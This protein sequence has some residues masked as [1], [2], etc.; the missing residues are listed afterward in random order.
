VS[1]IILKQHK[2]KLNKLYPVVMTTYDEMVS[3]VPENEEDLYLDAA[4]G[5]MS[6]TPD[7]L[8]GLPLGVECST[9]IRYGDAK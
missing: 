5:I 2:A 4:I 9:A 8:P 6:T 3:L 1:A 7:Y